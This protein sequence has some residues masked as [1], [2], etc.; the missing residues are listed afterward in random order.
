MAVLDGDLGVQLDRIILDEP[1][2]IERTMGLV[3]AIGQTGDDVA[4]L[5]FGLIENMADAVQH[6]VLAI[7]REQFVEAARAQTAGGHLGFHVAK[8][9]LGEA[10]VV[11]EDAIHLLVEFALLIDLDLIELQALLPGVGHGGAGAKACA[12]AANIDPVG[13]HHGEHQQLALEEIGHV[14]DD[15]VEV[16]ARHRLMVGDDDVAG[17]EALGAIAL[18]AVH[19]DHAEVGDEMGHAAYV[20]ADEIAIGGEQRGAEVADFVDHHVVGGALQIRRHFIGDGGQGVAD[21]LKG[22][23]VKPGAHA[24]PPTVMINSPVAATVQESPANMTVVVPC[25]CTMAGPSK[26]APAGSCSRS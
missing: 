8:G 18:H 9:R 14:D 20:L 5:L 12:H 22:D 15:V 23:G 26:C 2:V 13:A 21:H 3:D 6:G 1:V 10:N 25:S 16:L 19:H 4:A 24:T 11:P 7:F 17:L